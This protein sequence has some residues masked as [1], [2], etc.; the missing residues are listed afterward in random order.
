M[1]TFCFRRLAIACT[2]A[3]AFL[4]IILTQPSPIHVK[5]SLSSSDKN[6]TAVPQNGLNVEPSLIPSLSPTTYFAVVGA[7][8]ARVWRVWD[9]PEQWCIVKNNKVPGI[10]QGLLF[11]KTPKT[12]SSTIA[13]I[14]HRMAIWQGKRLFGNNGQWKNK[15]EVVCSFRNQHVN[16][17]QSF[18]RRNSQSSYLFTSVRHPSQRAMSRVFYTY[19]SD[20]NWSTSDESILKALNTTQHQFGAISPGQGGHQM[21]YITLH[22]IPPWSAWHPSNATHVIH[23][24]KVQQHAAK[25]LSGYDYV[26]VSDR[27]DESVVA[28]QLL[29][30]VPVSDVLS[31]STKVSGSYHCYRKKKCKQMQK[32]FVS[33]RVQ[34]FLTSPEWY[35]QN[36]GDF[37]LYEAASQSLDLTIQHLGR[38]RFEAALQNYRNVMQRLHNAC[39]PSFVPVCTGIGTPNPNASECYGGRDDGCGFRC[40][41]A[42]V[43]E[44]KLEFTR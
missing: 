30:G 40:I 8:L 20:Y 18:R 13:G 9:T 27:M 35:A 25:I 19:I 33:P 32:S 5:N 22:S 3:I 28:L 14:V 43:K 10:P 42:M 6:T 1:T 7:R 16:P 2:Y 26:M 29:L 37:I 4:W 39:A 24:N 21:A 17:Q 31:L 12:G 11:V 44:G 15:D 34:E 23:R 36:Y 38:A 41:D